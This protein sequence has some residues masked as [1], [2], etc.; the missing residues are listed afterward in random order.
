MALI[1]GLISSKSGAETKTTYI[2]MSV[3][4]VVFFILGLYIREFIY[5]LYDDIRK[6]EEK[7]RKI[8]EQIAKNE[9]Q[10]V[11]HTVDYRVDENTSE[12]N[13]NEA[14]INTEKGEKLY[15]EEF[16]PLNVNSVKINKDRSK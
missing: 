10:D 13:I 2:R 11:K 7:E 16:T 1:I 8:E 3:A 12:A 6:K 5:K 4:L 14:N 15:D 9:N